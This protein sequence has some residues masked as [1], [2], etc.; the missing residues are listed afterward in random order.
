MATEV[1]TALGIDIGGTRVRTGVVAA[2]G[3]LLAQL[4]STLPP[5]GDPEALG[6]LLADQ[7]RRAAAQAGSGPDATGIA[8]PGLW[9]R[10]TGIMEHAI[11]LPR[12]E[13][14]NI[15][16]LF[17]QALGRA[18]LLESDVNAAAWA[19]WQQIR[20]QPRRLVY[21]S[22]GT[23][24]GG[25]VILDGQIVRHTRGGAGHFG[26]LI[27]DTG[28]DAPIDRTGVRGSLSAL[29]AG[30]ALHT[31]S[32]QPG[33]AGAGGQPP[34]RH[35]IDK[36]ARALGV[37]FVDLVHI[38]APDTIIL[39]GGVTDQHPE[40]VDRARDA[41][42]EYHSRLIPADLRIAAAPLSSCEA[43]IIGAGLLALQDECPA[44]PGR[45]SGDP[46]A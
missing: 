33:P 45:R 3:Q 31:S 17:E 22:I 10:Q 16:R 12:L 2:T 42:A 44:A 27:V 4:E 11:N 23:G 40:M 7:A 29:A 28:P 41:F 20:P 43:G 14:V 26:F 24:V 37:A 32:G 39:G 8:L 35:A 15:R 1:R 30:P 9:D 6:E 25:S 34:S 21:V 18:V 46:C 13:G 19:Q 38:Y 36:A 5:E